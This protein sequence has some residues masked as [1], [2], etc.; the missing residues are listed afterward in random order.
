[1][2]KFQIICAILIVNGCA[3]APVEPEIGQ[4]FC[5]GPI[6]VKALHEKEYPFTLRGITVRFLLSPSHQQ[7]FLIAVTHEPL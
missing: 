2:T 3:S 4:P 1:M 5:D 7:E 6:A